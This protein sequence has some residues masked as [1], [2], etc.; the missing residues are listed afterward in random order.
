MQSSGFS[1]VTTAVRSFQV[2]A[3]GSYR[4]VVGAGL[5]DRN[6]SD[7]AL[8]FMRPWAMALVPRV[9]GMILGGAGLVGGLVLFA[10]KRTGKI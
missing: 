10:L 1:T 6:V 3:A 7:F 9:L 8:V 4:L 5:P 2:P